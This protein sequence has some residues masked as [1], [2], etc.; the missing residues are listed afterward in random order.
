MRREHPL[1]PH[2]LIL[3]FVVVTLAAVAVL[4]TRG[5]DWYRR[6]YHPLRYEG[7]ISEQSS[8]SGVDPYLVAALINAESGFR[9]GVVS[10]AGAVGLMQIKPSTARSMAKG[11]GVSGKI[12]V[13]TLSSPDQNIRVG[14][15]YLA[16]LLKRY[17]GD[18][19]SALAA[20]NA[21]LRHAD[22]W[23]EDAREA[24]GAF[25]E[26]IGFPETARYV[27]KVLEQ[28]ETYR[29]LYPGVLARP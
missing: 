18:A 19:T 11:A 20:Y 7:L 9:P 21:G 24:D 25:D 16:Y 3:V 15:R 2:R 23:A 1:W 13:Q 27:A 22:R 10:R 5:P 4:A 8:I 6:I 14:T 29:T 17:D 28:R 26:S 12:T